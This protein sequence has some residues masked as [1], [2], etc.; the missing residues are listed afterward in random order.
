M[1]VNRSKYDWFAEG[2]I[3][4]ER[5]SLLASALV[6]RL[7]RQWHP[8]AP[9]V[10]DPRGLIEWAQHYLPHHF[11][12]PPS[13][14]HRWLD[15]QLSLMQ[16]QRGHKLNVIGPRGS[17]KSTVGSLAWP[18][19]L[20]LT[21]AEPYIWIVSDTA[22][23]ACNHL[24]NIKTELTDNARLATDYPT[25]TGRGMPWSQQMIMLNNGVVIEAFGSGQRIRGRRFGA[26]RPT[27][28]IVDDL[29]NDQNIESAERRDRSRQWFHGT[30]L[31]AG[32]QR[33]NV[34]HLATA[35]H[36]EALAL[37]L[38]RTPGWKSHIF[39]AIERWPDHMYLWQ[40]WEV[41]YAD[42][43]GVNAS[44]QARAFYDEHRTAMDQGVEL[45]WPE[46]ED[47]YALMRMRVEGGRTAFEREKQGSP[48][49]S[50]ACEWPEAYFDQDI[51]FEQWPTS[52][53]IKVLALDP[54][55]GSD[56]SHGDYSAYVM[57][58]IDSRGVLYVEADLARRPTPQMV[59]DGVKLYGDF[60]P[61][62]FGI[63]ANQFQELLGG[64]IV[65][66]FQRRGCY[67]V[68]P[69]LM[70]NT[71]SKVVRIRRL[72]P[73]LSTRRIK[74]KQHSP[75]TRMLV[76][77]LKEFPLADHDDGPDALEMAI[78]LATELCRGN[79]ASD[80]LGDRFHLSV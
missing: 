75:A 34:I 37:E 68:Q 69:W 17:A 48:I 30:L 9:V 76:Q 39:R 1:P 10:V 52:L 19:R 54:S 70:H 50:D 32:T 26:Y 79:E 31:R 18:L 14:M 46:E 20:A 61:Q 16:Q 36:S 28:I 67:G 57:L 45:L 24:Q 22:G 66:E 49:L 59:S 63:E 51:W 25:A 72:G 4:A 33:T 62:A 58:G 35:L 13:R 44:E 47:L 53:T 3:S 74:F 60:Q 5:V 21:G 8:T 80:G 73:F 71:V 11:S 12:R 55:K 2:D 56:A 65:E 27:L 38:D 41:L 43:D 23:Q 15:E 64:L 77:Q 6:R 7:Q 40:Q 42:V 78:R 29:Q